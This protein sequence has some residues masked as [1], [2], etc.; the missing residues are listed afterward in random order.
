MSFEEVIQDLDALPEVQKLRVLRHHHNVNR[1]DHSLRV[2]LWSFRL[3]R[4]L[5][6]DARACAR[7]GMLHDLFLHD[8]R[9]GKPEGWKGPLI[10]TH[11]EEAEL[12]AE[13]LVTLSPREKNIILS[14]MWPT[15][16]HWPRYR[17]SWL[18]SMV[19]KV[20]AIQ[21]YATTKSRA[22]ARAARS[23]FRLKHS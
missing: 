3:A 20:V 12:N 21:D 8:S 13:R 9:T 11:P 14:H 4:M 18:V 15:T 5:G 19:D 1:Y 23:R 17:E 6:W 10:I 7:A 2:A 16:R 22:Q